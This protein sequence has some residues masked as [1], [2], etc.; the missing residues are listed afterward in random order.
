MT[1]YDNNLPLSRRS[2]NLFY[3]ATSLNKISTMDSHSTTT[4]DWQSKILKKEYQNWLAVGHA[5]S[6]M[7][8]G[9]RPY[10]DREMK[11]F[12]QALLANLRFA[13]PCTCPTSFPKHSFSCAWAA[14]LAMYHRGSPKWHQ[15]D[16]YIWTD[17]NQGYWEVAKL[18]MPDL[19]TSKSTVVDAASTDCTGL[20]NLLFWCNY[21]RI[22]KFLAKAVRETR[23][24]KWGHAARQELTD[25]EKA[26]ALTAIKNLLQD[27][28]LAADTDAVSAL[29]E[30]DKMEKD[31][32]AR[33]VERKVQADF[34][35]EV[36]CK[37][38]AIEDEMNDL[39]TASNKAIKELQNQQKKVLEIVKNRS[40]AIKA[41]SFLWWTLTKMKTR[42]FQSMSSLNTR[43]LSLWIVT[44]IF[45]GVIGYLNHNSFKDGKYRYFLLI[46]IYEYD[47]IDCLCAGYRNE[48]SGYQPWPGHS[49]LFLSKI[50]HSHGL[51][52]GYHYT[53][54][55]QLDSG[56]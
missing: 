7:C 35:V 23:N 13:S 24:T 21:F 52:S 1:I 12:H 10:I 20:I 51:P 22:Q 31:F 28:E 14:Q 39:N 19:G 56:V 40:C 53:L 26:D 9:L 38:S 42:F 4:T 34:R 3:L 30:I 54:F 45:M 25:I 48:Q 15:S 11:A 6:L 32:D 29:A 49:A 36:G 44:L 37:L 27:T 47:C 18:F 2:S 17:P 46:A 55:E 5:L 8:D 16:P 33:S 50:F 41:L 43:Y